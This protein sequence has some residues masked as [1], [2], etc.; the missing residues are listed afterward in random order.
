MHHKTAVPL[1]KFGRILELLMLKNRSLF[2][3]EKL[4]EQFSPY[5]M[6]K[7]KF[8]PKTN[9]TDKHILFSL[10]CVKYSLL[11]KR[12]VNKIVEKNNLLKKKET[13]KKKK[14]HFN[15]STE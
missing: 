12:L 14:K 9:I 3:R 15:Y 10:Q 6:L 11:P 5:G 1:K 8:P 13:K 7:K 2:D 4:Y